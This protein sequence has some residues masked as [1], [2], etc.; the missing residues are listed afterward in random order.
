[1]KWALIIGFAALFPAALAA[2]PADANANANAVGQL[3]ETLTQPS[4]VLSGSAEHQRLVAFLA[5][6][7]SALTGL[8]RP[9]ATFTSR[10]SISK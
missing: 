7:Q 9:T 2:Q 4:V 1:M 6:T 5:R 3:T 10:I 8:A